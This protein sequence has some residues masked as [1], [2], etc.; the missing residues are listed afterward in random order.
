MRTVIRHSLKGACLGAATVA[1]LAAGPWARA[2]EVTNVKDGDVF[3]Y[4]LV[5]VEGSAKGALQVKTTLPTS[6]DTTVA[7]KFRGVVEL[8]AGKNALTFK[9]DAGSATLTLTY[10]PPTAKE[11]RVKIWYVVPK[12]EDPLKVKAFQID[13]LYQTKLDILTKVM[14]SWIA[15]DLKRGGYGPKTFYPEFRKDDPSKVDVGLLYANQ[16]RAQWD[17]QGNS[18][19]IAKSVLPKK[20]DTPT[21]R[22]VAFITCANVAQ[23]SDNFCVIGYGTLVAKSPTGVAD[24]VKW[25]QTSEPDAA[26]GALSYRAFTGV[27]LHE[28]GHMIHW[29]WHPGGYNLIQDAYE[30]VGEAFTVGMAPG[31]PHNEADRSSYGVQQELFNTSRFFSTTGDERTYKNGGFTFSTKGGTFSVKADHPLGAVFYYL[32]DNTTQVAKLDGKKGKTWEMRIAD[33][34]KTLNSGGNFSYMAVDVE[35]N[36]AHGHYVPPPPVK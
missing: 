28:F 34:V 3:H 22:N 6:L 25:M 23:S 17:A 27:T 9:D 12:G 4:P 8:K 30:N 5:V 7:N 31:V 21:W 11:Y 29:A 35:G 15:E 16:T 36:E 32:P 18:Y 24:I 13:S 2:V 10:K 19:D 20:Y 33:I 1:L 26:Q 14:Q